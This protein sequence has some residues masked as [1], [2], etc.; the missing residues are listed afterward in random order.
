MVMKRLKSFF[1]LL[2]Y[3][4]LVGCGKEVEEVKKAN[5]ERAQELDSN[6]FSVHYKHVA[7]SSFHRNIPRNANFRIL[8]KFSFTSETAITEAIEIYYNVISEPFGYEFKCIYL[9]NNINQHFEFSL[10]SNSVGSNLGNVMEI[11]FMLDQGKKIIIQSQETHAFEA[12][13]PHQVAWK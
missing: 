9:P 6:T 1:L 4:G 12:Q 2:P 10:C 5:I 3:L 11:D 8:D 7:L 13:L